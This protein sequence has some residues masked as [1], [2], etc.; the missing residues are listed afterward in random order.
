MPATD[1]QLSFNTNFELSQFMR[2]VTALLSRIAIF[3]L[4]V[5]I[6]FAI[7]YIF[8]PKQYKSIAIL[9]P[10]VPSDIQKQ[11]SMGGGISEVL[12]IASN[13]RKVE[14]IDLVTAVI[15]SKDFFE[16]LSLENNFLPK[17]WAF[18]SIG[19]KEVVY[20]V[21]KYDVINNKWKKGVPLNLFNE[22]SLEKSHRKF[23]KDH[24]KISQK[25]HLGDVVEIQVIHESPQIALEWAEQ[26]ISLINQT[27]QKRDEIA[28]E[29]SISFLESRLITSNN[30]ELRKS[31]ARL[32]EQQFDKLTVTQITD[33]YSL[34]IIDS[35]RRPEQNF[36]PSILVF[37][38]L[39][40]FMGVFVPLL[41]LLLLNLLNFQVKPASKIPWVSLHKNDQ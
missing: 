21:D 2:Q 40:L 12:N 3:C 19:D 11:S 37:S 39:I 22:P 4:L 28:A 6:F 35:P 5:T 30:L 1:N 26:L 16:T 14:Y 31:I 41:M 27:M 25:K 13:S 9:E 24:F 20:K 10:I 8:T 23:H 36:Y 15:N 38:A 17:L 7:I 32:I 33:E 34:K 18:E 29:K